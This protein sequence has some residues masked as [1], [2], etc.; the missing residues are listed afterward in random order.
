M[1]TCDC[2]SGFSLRAKEHEMRS[3]R[4]EREEKRMKELTCD[5][6]KEVLQRCYSE[7]VFDS[8]LLC[9]MAED[10]EMRIKRDEKVNMENVA[11]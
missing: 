5:N 2:G 11:F 7:F 10:R 4:H 3:L 1:I 9:Y 8:C 6:F